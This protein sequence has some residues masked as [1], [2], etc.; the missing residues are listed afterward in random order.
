MVAVNEGIRIV[1]FLSGSTE[2]RSFFRKRWIIIKRDGSIPAAQLPPPHRYP[3]EK[4][5]K[6]EGEPATNQWAIWSRPHGYH[7]RRCRALRG[8][9]SDVAP[10]N[11]SR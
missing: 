8:R 11:N 10:R 5:T 7:Q 9:S 3:F 6:L 1:E 4:I 2:I